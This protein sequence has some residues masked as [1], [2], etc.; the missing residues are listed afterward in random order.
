VRIDGAAYSESGI[1]STFDRA[2]DFALDLQIGG[3]GILYGTTE[4][5]YSGAAS[6]TTERGSLTINNAGEIASSEEG[7]VNLFW[8]RDMQVTNSGTISTSSGGGGLFKSAVTFFQGENATLVNSGLIERS[9]LVGAQASGAAAVS[10]TNLTENVDL[11]NT[12]TITSLLTAIFSSA[13]L[14][15]RVTNAGSVNGNLLLSGIGGDLFN[16]GLIDGDVNANGGD[17]DVQNI[18]TIVG[19]V[20]LGDGG[21]SMWPKGPDTYQAKSRAGS[22]TTQSF[23]EPRMI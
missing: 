3:D 14:S 11:H 19:D 7:A 13:T 8:A 10:F 12:G 2:E 6:T 1:S 23:P 18:G 4:A 20:D 22:E 21:A 5:L 9:N 17:D 15:E 16:S